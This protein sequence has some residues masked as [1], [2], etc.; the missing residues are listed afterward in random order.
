MTRL[1]AG[2][3]W[4]QVFAAGI[5]LRLVM[6]VPAMAS[7]GAA[8]AIFALVL[9]LVVALAVFTGSRIAIAIGI[10]AAIVGVAGLFFAMS[11][12]DTTLWIAI[13]L[14][15]I[16]LTLVGTLAWRQQRGALD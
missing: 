5:L 7:L 16:A 11:F 13:G 15:S 2:I 1:P 12:A 8:S 9:N 14:Y 4:N 10:Y 6:F 3:R